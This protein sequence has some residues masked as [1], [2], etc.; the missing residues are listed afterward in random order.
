LQCRQCIAGGGFATK[1]RRSYCPHKANG[2]AAALAALQ[3]TVLFA[4]E[5]SI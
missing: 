4:I 3:T 1:S 5:D 2:F